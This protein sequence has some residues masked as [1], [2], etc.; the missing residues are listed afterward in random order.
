M[1][2]VLIV[3]SFQSASGSF[4][5]LFQVIFPSKLSANYKV[6]ESLS[7]LGAVSCASATLNKKAVVG[8]AADEI[9]KNLFFFGLQDKTV[10]LINH[11]S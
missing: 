3:L 11:L 10:T 2:I 7:S 9:Q 1:L 8:G 6:T 5:H 4:L